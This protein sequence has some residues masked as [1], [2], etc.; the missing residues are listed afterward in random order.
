VNPID[1]LI[2]ELS[3]LPSV[4][5]K[6]AT[7]LA[8]FILRAPNDYPKKL[9]LAV[10]GVANSL[11]YCDLCQNIAESERCEI[12]S[13]VQREDTILC[14]VAEPSDVTAIEKTGSFRGRY[15]V[16][17]GVLSPLQAVGPD[18]LRLNPLMEQL[19]ANNR[20]QEIVLALNPN[21]EGEATSLYLQD[22]L[23]DFKG[24]ITRLA[25]GIPVGGDLEYTDAMTLTRA[26]EQRIQVT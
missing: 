9:A 26:L 15:Y 5:E 12:C 21:A 20:V 3:K 1:R 22:L 7:R 25:S 4:G 14:V 8:Y 17:H 13:N 2:Q 18:Q 24:R 23:K 11:H 16:L 19:Q 10:E 6:T